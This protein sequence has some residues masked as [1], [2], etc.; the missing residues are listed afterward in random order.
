MANYNSVH[1]GL[2]I[3]N[4][5]TDVI[6]KKWIEDIPEASS[7]PP[8]KSIEYN[9]NGTQLGVR[10][11]GE[12]SYTYTDLKGSTGPAGTPP[13]PISGASAPT[14]STAG[15]LAQLYYTTGTPIRVFLC[16]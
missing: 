16:T 6:G 3:D 14:T 1:K 11:Q 4:A 13:T 15:V 12:P 5:V 9:W 2:T 10:V 8:G 7:G